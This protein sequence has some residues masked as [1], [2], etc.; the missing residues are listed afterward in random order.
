M[1]EKVE[2]MIISIYFGSSIALN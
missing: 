1:L 2:H